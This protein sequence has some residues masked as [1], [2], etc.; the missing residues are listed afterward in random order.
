MKIKLGFLNE[1]CDVEWRFIA[2]VVVGILKI[3]IPRN[4][5][6]IY[7]GELNRTNHTTICKLYDEIKLKKIGRNNLPPHNHTPDYLVFNQK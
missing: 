2:N 1:T 4:I 7:S 6:L 3:V 5:F